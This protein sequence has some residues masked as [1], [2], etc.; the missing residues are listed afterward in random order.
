[1]DTMSPRVHCHVVGPTLRPMAQVEG[2][3]ATQRT[4]L[5]TM[6]PQSLRRLPM[7]EE[8]IHLGHFDPMTQAQQ[9]QV[10]ETRFETAT[11]LLECQHT[12]QEVQADLGLEI[13]PLALQALG[14]L[15]ATNVLRVKR[16]QQ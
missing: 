7:E 6:H 12:V 14:W 8:V 16:S 1:M 2:A 13:H 3:A 10:V 15:R 4:Q 9:E 5:L 11:W